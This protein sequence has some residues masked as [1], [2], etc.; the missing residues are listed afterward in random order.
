MA[1]HDLHLSSDLL[2]AF[3]RLSEILGNPIVLEAFDHYDAK[4]RRAK[5]IYVTLG[6][7]AVTSAVL[8][9][10]WQIVSLALRALGEDRIHILD[11]PS[12][13]LGIFAVLCIIVS[14]LLD[15]RHKWLHNVFLRERLRQWRHQL[16]LDAELLDIPASNSHDRTKL[17][18]RRWAQFLHD[19]RS[20]DGAYQ[21]FLGHAD[22][23]NWSRWERPASIPIVNDVLELQE[24][25]RIEY[26]MQYAEVKT[27]VGGKKPSV[28]DLTYLSGLAATFTFAAAILVSVVGLG[29]DIVSSNSD[30]ISVLSSMAIGLAVA[31]AGVRAARAGLTLPSERDSYEEYL[32]GLS[33]LRAVYASSQDPDTKWRV[34]VQ[35]ERLAVQELRQFLRMKEES[36]FVF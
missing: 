12:T 1:N 4:A 16:L 8:A 30:H 6:L 21:A 14:R 25:L 28:T 11:T 20:V 13:F 3:P 22:T 5:R 29:V 19:A 9:I 36:R 17:L 33:A 26:Q 18:A 7:L 23:Q 10:E 27:A 2:S 34:L 24:Q 32:S 31:S 15:M 35:V